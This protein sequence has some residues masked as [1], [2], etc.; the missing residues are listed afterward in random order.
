M[1][2]GKYTEFAHLKMLALEHAMAYGLENSCN[3]THIVE[4]AT[5]FYLFLIDD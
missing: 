1:P 3:D 2:D 4:T 5:K